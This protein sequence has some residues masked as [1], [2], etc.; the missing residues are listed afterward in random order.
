MAHKEKA[1]VP[2]LDST[3]TFLVTNPCLFNRTLVLASNNP[4]EK[5]MTTQKPRIVAPQLIGLS[6]LVYDIEI[7]K[8]ICPVNEAPIP[9]IEYCEGWHDHAGMGI[10]V[11]NAYD[12]YEDR[13]RCFCEDNFDA[14]QELV[15]DREVICGFNS[16]RFDNAVCEAN[17]IE[18][19]E[20]KSYDILREMWLSAGLGAEFNRTTHR[21]Y[22]LD[23]TGEV[24]LGQNK[25]GHGALAPVQWQRGEIGKVIDY[26]LGD[27]WITKRLLD[28]ILI[29]QELISPADGMTMLRMPIPPQLT[30]MGN[31]V[32]GPQ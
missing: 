10:S 22:G 25:T 3:G 24:N 14:F 27:V 16:I 28:L 31:A 9:G 15:E 13:Y 29:R 19:P 12:Y 30:M 4:G 21:N 11:I 20:L 32:A 23:K 26:C 5:S 6:I 2:G 7:V 17:G 1:V 18:V 8:G